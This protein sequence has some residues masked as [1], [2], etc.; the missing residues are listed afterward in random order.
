MNVT[1]NS[2]FADKLGK[3][4]EE[5]HITQNQLAKAIGVS[6][7]T[8]QHWLSGRSEP[9]VSEGFS[10]AEHFNLSMYEM[11]GK[12]EPVT[13]H[14]EHVMI[15]QEIKELKELYRQNNIEK[16]RRT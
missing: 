9:K 13:L 8:V 6:R 3:L 10:L 16:E 15:L 1:T 14:D 11:F 4:M 7:G 12:S 5:R 2:T